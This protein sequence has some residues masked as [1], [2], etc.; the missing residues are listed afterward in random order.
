MEFLDTKVYKSSNGKLQTTLYTKPTDRQSYLHNKSYH[1]SSCKR[2]IAYSQALR[3][4]RIC[5]EAPEFEQHTKK[6]SAKLV[7][8]GYDQK[9]VDEQI[10]KARQT[11]R[12]DLLKPKDP[13]PPAKNIL[14][15]TYNKGLPN[16]KKAID[17]NWN[18]LS[19]NPTLAPLFREKPILAFRRNRN[20]Q[21]LVCKHKL[22]NNK[23]VQKVPK[24]HGKCR[25]C[26][27][28]P[29]NKCCKQMASTT[30][31]TNRKTG[32]KF[33]IFHNLNCRSSK[34]IYLI[35]CTLCGNK[36]YV[37]KSETASNLRTNNHRHD[38]KKPDSIMIDK[39]FYETP[40]H[41][42][43]KHAKITLIEQL[44]NAENMTKEEITFNLE[45]REDFWMIKLNTL[46]PDGFN[47]ALNH[48]Q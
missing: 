38:A 8:R 36:P 4:K 5:S 45:K 24:K 19:I 20:L 17:D 29:K 6:L 16:L 25:P 18:I 41:D 15:V 43:E 28:D 12:L 34:V 42:F 33:Q 1:P 23:P 47:I 22:K 9:L 32:R 27:T 10:D 3:I 2:S 13:T 26:L 31:F 48:S 7:Q 11:D 21:N 30:H 46:Q 37:G 35:E 40:G 44:R 14:A 39:H